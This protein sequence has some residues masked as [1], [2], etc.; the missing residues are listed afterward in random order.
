MLGFKDFLSE[1]GII[2]VNRIRHGQVQRRVAVTRMAGYKVINGKLVKMSS[3]EKM[4]RKLGQRV[5][6]RKRVSK[7]ATMLRKRA[8][9]IRKRK[10]AGIK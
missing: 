4:H 7:I 6:A 9:S 8:M 5:G 10:S 2:K 3:Q 1:A